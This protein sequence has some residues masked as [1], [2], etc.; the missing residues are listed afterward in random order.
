[1]IDLAKF[2]GRLI[3]PQSAAV[4]LLDPWNAASHCA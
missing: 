3:M 1:M 4:A 2:M